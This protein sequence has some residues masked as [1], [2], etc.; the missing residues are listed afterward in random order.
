MSSELN[1]L[2]ELKQ[3]CINSKENLNFLII[4]LRKNKDNGI[5]SKS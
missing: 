4:D 1:E 5:L 3:Q 2:L